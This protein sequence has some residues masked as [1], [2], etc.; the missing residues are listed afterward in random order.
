LVHA[1]P[2]NN[3]DTV[4]SH[5]LH[6]IKTHFCTQSLYR[7]REGVSPQ[8]QAMIQT[9]FIGTKSRRKLLGAYSTATFTTGRFLLFWA[10][11]GILLCPLRPS[12][13]SANSST[14]ESPPQET[15]ATLQEAH[16]GATFLS[17]NNGSKAAAALFLLEKSKA[18]SSP[19]SPSRALVAGQ[20]R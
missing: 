5:R 6:V 10:H 15:L 18:L 11:A 9:V 7:G 20:D 3:K 14:L 16:H 12:E 19:P 4:D 8:L 17:T 1:A 2:N 13:N